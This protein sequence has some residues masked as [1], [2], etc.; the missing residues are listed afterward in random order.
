NVSLMGQSAGAVNVYAMLTS[1]LIVDARHKLFHRLIPPS[2]GLSLA[3]ELPPGSIATLAPAS[4]YQGH[5]GFLF[6][7]QLIADGT[8]ADA[9]AANT[10]IASHTPQQLAQYLRSRTAAQLLGTVLTRLAPVGASGSG[11]IPDGAVLPID[12]VLEITAGNY[13]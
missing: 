7:Q 8:A 3:T 4:A 11:P 12:P 6:Q 2:G 9:A 10:Y 1:P 13:L 5:G